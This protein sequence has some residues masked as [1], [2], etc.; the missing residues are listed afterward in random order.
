MFGDQTSFAGWFEAWRRETGSAAHAAMRAVNPA[1]IPRNHRVEEAIQRGYQGDFAPFH[2]LVDALAAPY[3][4]RPE[5]IDLE[6]PPTPD[7]VVRA[8]FCGT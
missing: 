8:T 5:Y 3:E 2:R 1:R 7:E 6:T 4:D